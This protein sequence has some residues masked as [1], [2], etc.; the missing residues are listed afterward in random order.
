MWEKPDFKDKYHIIYL[1]KILEYYKF[2]YESKKE[3]KGKIKS[4]FKSKGWRF[5]FRGPKFF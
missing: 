5:D 3:F 2:T 1:L 4:D